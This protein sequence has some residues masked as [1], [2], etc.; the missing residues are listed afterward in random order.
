MKLLINLLIQIYYTTHHYIT[1]FTIALDTHWRLQSRF[2]S[3]IGRR[4]SHQWQFHIFHLE[5][6]RS[7]F[8]HSWFIV[9]L[10]SSIRWLTLFLC[11]RLILTEKEIQTFTYRS[12]CST[13]H[14]T[15]VNIAF[16][17]LPVAR[18]GLTFLPVSR[19]PLAWQFMV[20]SCT[21]PPL[22]SSQ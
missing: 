20:I 13:H 4:R 14:T 7:N 11:N 2:D 15:W 22:T 9:R 5:L 12:T 1:M 21:P 3:S 17:L 8:P 18:T 6:W 10:P 19:D 16:I